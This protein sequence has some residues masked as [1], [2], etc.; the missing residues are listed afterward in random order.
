MV[1]GILAPMADTLAEIKELEEKIAQKKK[2]Y[3]DQLLAEIEER[4]AKLRE[5]GHPLYS[6]DKP[7]RGRKPGSSKKGSTK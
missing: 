4:K 1:F 2:E 5:L 6:D 3:A 7:K